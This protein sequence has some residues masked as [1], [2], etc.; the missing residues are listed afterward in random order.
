MTTAMAVSAHMVGR[1]SPNQFCRT[2]AS[3][4]MKNW[5]NEP[6]AEQMPTASACLAGGATRRTTPSTGPNEAADRPMPTRMLP[7]ISM[8]PS[9][10][11]AV[12]TMPST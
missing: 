9:C 10:M 1:Q 12:T 2:A 7:R 5:P 4:T 3:G 8:K 6:P 11:M